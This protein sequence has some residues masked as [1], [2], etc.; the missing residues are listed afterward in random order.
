[1]T[2]RFEIDF[3]HSHSINN[4]YTQLDLVCE[5]K[6]KI[7]M[8]SS[9]S[10]IALALG[11]ALFT[12]QID[13]LGRRPMVLMF[14]AI[15]PLGL[16]AAQYFCH[17]LL[18]I[19]IIMFLMGLSY[20][21]RQSAAFMYGGEFVRKDQRMLMAYFTF[22]ITG[23]QHGLTG[24]WFWWSQDQRSFHWIMFTITTLTLFY[25]YL[26]VPESPVFL[27]EMRRFSKLRECFEKIAWFNGVT[28]PKIVARYCELQLK[29]VASKND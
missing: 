12:N 7:G 18:N 11:G 5:P 25:V 20:S 16:L 19:Q 13:K 28:E 10:S 2:R 23:F 21:T 3:E 17:N 24:L 29:L 6:Y 27:Y 22:T 1:M 4:W 8:L 15:T 14:G 9:V 26:C